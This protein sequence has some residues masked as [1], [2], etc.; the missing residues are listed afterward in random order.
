[1]DFH[2]KEKQ[3]ER[4]REAER[5]SYQS[6]RMERWSS[7]GSREAVKKG[8][9]VKRFP[10]VLGSS[11]TLHRA[12]QVLFRL[13]ALRFARN[14]SQKNQPY[15][16]SVCMMYSVFCIA[17]DQDLASTSNFESGGTLKFAETD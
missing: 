7:E 6:K 14:K 13:I 12:E 10:P 3:R 8:S 17:E 1:M 9:K 16:L 15:N 11:A 5:W 2:T 4:E